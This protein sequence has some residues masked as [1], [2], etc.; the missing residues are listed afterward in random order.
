MKADGEQIA[1]K[2]KINPDLKQDMSKLTDILIAKYTVANAVMNATAK[3]TRLTKA[4]DTATRMDEVVVAIENV[5]RKQ[6]EILATATKPKGREDNQYNETEP[7]KKQKIEEAEPAK[8]TARSGKKGGRTVQ[9]KILKKPTQGTTGDNDKRKSHWAKKPVGYI[10]DQ[11][12]KRGYKIPAKLLKGPTRLKKIRFSRC[13][14][15][16]IKI[17]YELM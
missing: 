5:K 4:K 17:L 15:I 2:A 9:V 14:T 10:K 7:P 16:L 13:Y 12:D 3:G 8:K 6:D 11:L 1:K